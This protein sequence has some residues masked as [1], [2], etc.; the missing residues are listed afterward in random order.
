MIDGTYKIEV[1]NMIGPK[2]GKAT[3]QTDGDKA[4]IDID[5]PVLGKQH[6]EG[7]L[8]GENGF[9]AQ[10]SF[11]LFLIGK[12]R[13]KLRGEVKG[14]TMHTLIKSNRG[15]FDIAGKRVS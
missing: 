8:E 15:F 12:V 7:Q 5:M 10:G 11:G 2:G 4:I 9:S 6:A 14:D 13:Y 3:L 1:R